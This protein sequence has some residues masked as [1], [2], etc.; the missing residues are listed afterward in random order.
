MKSFPALG[1]LGF[2][3]SQVVPSNNDLIPG[4]YSRGLIIGTAGT[5]NVT[6]PDGT[7]A[8]GI[9]ATEGFFPF[10]VAKVRTGG[11][12]SNIWTVV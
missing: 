3:S 7:T 9:P 6:F 4:S 12:A 8:D 11:T 2:G 5:L 10:F 1:S